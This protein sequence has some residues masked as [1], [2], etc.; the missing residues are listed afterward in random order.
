MPASPPSLWISLLFAHS[1][2]AFSQ[3]MTT[4]VMSTSS[5][6]CMLSSLPG[7]CLSTLFICLTQLSMHFKSLFIHFSDF[8]FIFLATP[9]VTWNLSSSTRTNPW[10]LQW[11]YGVLTT[12]PPG[13][14]SSLCLNAMSLAR[15]LLSPH[16]HICTH[17]NIHECTHISDSTLCLI[18]LMKIIFHNYTYISWTMWLFF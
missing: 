9:H 16:A 6:T 1:L 17:T 10:P 3:F 2:P 18:M 15:S 13:T 5:P 11:K 7:I 12:G 4:A 8:I 14:S